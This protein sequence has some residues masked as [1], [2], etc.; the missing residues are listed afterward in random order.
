[1][2]ASAFPFNVT[3]PS[4]GQPITETDSYGE[5]QASYVKR[6]SAENQAHHWN[7]VLRDD[8]FHGPVSGFKVG[9]A[10][11]KWGRRYPL[12]WVPVGDESA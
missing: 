12:I 5:P 7:E 3:S 10:P 8:P 2:S 4:L 1:M 9:V 11:V 6:A